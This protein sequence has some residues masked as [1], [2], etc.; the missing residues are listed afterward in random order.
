MDDLLPT[1]KML[2]AHFGRSLTNTEQACVLAGYRQG[3]AEEDA[4][5]ASTRQ[6]LA[7]IADE[8]ASLDG[9]SLRVGKGVEV[10]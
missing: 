1:I 4:A 8:L 2:E 3:L 6:T 10:V 7:V 9:D 5:L